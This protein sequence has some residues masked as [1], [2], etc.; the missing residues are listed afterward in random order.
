MESSIRHGIC[1]NIGFIVSMSLDKGELEPETE[2]IGLTSADRI[3]RLTKGSEI[4]DHIL[5]RVLH[6]HT[7]RNYKSRGQ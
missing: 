7:E 5:A 4:V 2:I 3:P 6:W 1:H